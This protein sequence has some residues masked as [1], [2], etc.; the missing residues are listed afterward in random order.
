MNVFEREICKLSTEALNAFYESENWAPSELNKLVE[1]PPDPEMGDYSLPC[2]SFAKIFKIPPV[3]VAEELSEILKNFINSNNLI[4]SVTAV[5]AYINFNISVVALAEA[6]LPEIFSGRYFKEPSKNTLERVMIEYS[7]PNTH[8]GF[9][10]GHLRNVSLG[11]SL[12]RIFKYNGY[13]V[14]GVNYIGDVGAHIAKCLWFFHN[15]NE[16]SPPEDFRGEWLGELYFRAIKKLDE[17]D[18]LQKNIFLKEISL[19]L[20]KLE[21]KDLEFIDEWEVT[22]QWSI[23]DFNE[24]YRWLDVKFDHIFYESEVDEE[25][26]RI[27]IKGLK[28]GLFVRSEGAV[29]ID[30]NKEELGF[31]ML[32][33]SDG[34]TLYAT[35]DLALAQLKFEKF[36]VQRSI[37]VVGA[38]QTLHFKQVFATLKR[39]G[40]KQVDRCFHLPYALV[41]LPEGKMSSRVGNVIL[42]SQLRKEIIKNIKSD[43]LY[44]HRKDW[45]QQELEE[46]AQ[47]IAVAAIKY[48]MLSQDSNKD[49][50]FSMKEWLIS[51]G[52]TG[53]YLVYA[54]VRIRSIVRQISQ[55]VRA[56][57]D[58]SLFSHPDEKKLL[59]QMLDFNRIV[60]NSGE[61][62]RPSLLARMLYDFSKDFSRAYNSCSVKHAESEVLKTARLLLFHCVAE[63]LLQGLSLLGITPPE[64]M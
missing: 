59:R 27:V 45:S 6:V 34:N 33:K 3:K 24:I 50:V 40:Y 47:K 7:Q 58:Y 46:T 20:K 21:E 52:D 29:G 62:F 28:K 23:E 30:L 5:G 55:R 4:T 42:F 2:F 43:Y 31:L 17:A 64:R 12:C 32:L 54:Y 36:G 37:Y 49:I 60:F 16:E 51:E 26:K 57:I 41:M 14:I 19:I 38:E 22:R 1:Q 48:G 25:G 35:K 63:T 56:D 18:V 44:E 11:D 13:D 61:Q 39:M 8:K 15:Y 9:H 53:T 10:V